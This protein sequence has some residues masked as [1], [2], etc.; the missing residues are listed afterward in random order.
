MHKTLL[1]TVAAL[2]S[3]PALANSGHILQVHHGADCVEF[4]LVEDAN[5]ACG[6]NVYVG[7]TLNP[8]CTALIPWYGIGT[9]E[10]VGQTP[11]TTPQLPFFV[12]TTSAIDTAYRLYQSE[13]QLEY[14]QAGIQGVI[15]INNPSEVA[16]LDTTSAIG[17]TVNGTL[18]CKNISATTGTHT[19]NSVRNLN[20][21]AS[22]FQVP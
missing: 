21:P 22:F 18:T 13:L 3:T 4:A 15:V 17:F 9:G 16:S 1:A 14:A 8:E 10:G 2:I 12:D 7:G 19:V 11:L 5:T 6:P 20:T